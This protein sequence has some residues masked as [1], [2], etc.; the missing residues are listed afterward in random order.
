MRRVMTNKKLEGE[1]TVTVDAGM[2]NLTGG[3]V[4]S[5]R[6]LRQPAPQTIHRQG[7]MPLAASQSPLPAPST[8][9]AGDCRCH[10]ATANEDTAGR[11]VVGEDC[12]KRP[13]GMSR[14][15]LV[16]REAP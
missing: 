9:S 3:C 5:K 12:G 1:R 6:Y 14:S 8:D 2:M 7:C 4:S 15:S 13:L 10:G 16:F 11:C